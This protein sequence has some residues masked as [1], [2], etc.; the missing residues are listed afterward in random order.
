MVDAITALLLLLSAFGVKWI[1]KIILISLHRKEKIGRAL[2][3]M[4]TVLAFTI[5]YTVLHGEPPSAEAIILMGIFV[6]H[7][8]K[9]EDFMPVA[10]N[11]D[12]GGT[13]VQCD[14]NTTN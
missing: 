2:T 12:T 6:M 10:D 8:A 14:R 9:D 11:D 1:I 3:I 5:A 7:L 13:L 4:L